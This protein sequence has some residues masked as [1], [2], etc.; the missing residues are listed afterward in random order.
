MAHADRSGQRSLELQRKS[1]AGQPEVQRGIH[2]VGQVFVVEDAPGH[3][4][5]RLARHKL[6]R[7]EFRGVKLAHL[8]ENGS[9]QRLLAMTHADSAWPTMSFDRLDNPLFK[10]YSRLPVQIALR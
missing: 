10:L 3:L 8:F 1:A 4:Y 7:A 2:Q 6:V 9:S 5:R